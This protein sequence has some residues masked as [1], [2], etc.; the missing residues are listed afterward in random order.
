MTH[1]G[2]GTGPCGKNAGLAAAATLMPAPCTSAGTLPDTVRDG[3][4]NFPKAHGGKEIWEWLEVRACNGMQ[5]CTTWLR[6]MHRRG[7]P[8]HPTLLGCRQRLQARPEWQENFNGAMQSVD[9]LARAALVTDCDWARFSRFIDVGGAYG[10]VLNALLLAVPGATGAR[11]WWQAD[12]PCS[13]EPA[14]H[15]ARAWGTQWASTQRLFAYV[16]NRCP[17]RCPV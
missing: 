6:V 9:A 8:S 10:S 16:S 3:Q 13:R 14:A 11:A 15:C 4:P 12:R 2:T 17:R 1:Q 5:P 7:R